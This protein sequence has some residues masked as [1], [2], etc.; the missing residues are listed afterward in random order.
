M[1][2]LFI[3]LGGIGQRHLRNLKQLYPDAEIYAIRKR[4]QNFVLTDKLQIEE[5]EKLEDKY[6][7]SLINSL[8]EA[9]E[10]GIEYVFI[11]NPSSLHMEYLLEAL[12]YKFHIFIEKP[13]GDS[14]KGIND[15]KNGLNKYPKTTMVGY[16]NRLHPCIK[17]AK[18]ILM[19]DGVGKIC[20]VH[21]EIGEN[22]TGWHKYEDYRKMY[23]CRKDLG[24]GVVLSQIHELDYLY[25]FFG[26]PQSVYAIGG[27]LSDLEIDVED[28]VDILMSFNNGICSF[29]VHVHED[30]LQNPAARC[31]KI[32][33]T[34]GVLEFDLLAA[35]I[36][37]YDSLGDALL[38]QKYNFV[39]ND[40]FIEE[41]QD[42]MQNS[43]SNNP[44]A[45]PIEE[46]LNSLYIAFAVKKAID[47]KQI[48]FLDNI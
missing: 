34:N 3:G 28:T 35:R 12:K 21:A 36:K 4:R 20:S 11:C 17:K 29:P 43:M 38:D 46:G 24:G 6:H 42:F 48:V 25:Y 37:L 44:S 13:L 14:P 19:R 2:V 10:N 41:L 26:M 22:V 9:S 18:E 8:K 45:I 1:K 5:G 39:R 23:A 31:C 47:E 16:Q 27:K 30:Y 33:G 7:I 40:M 32:I 15:L